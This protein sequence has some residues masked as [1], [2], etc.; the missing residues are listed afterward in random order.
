[1]KRV[2][3]KKTESDE[4]IL[5]ELT[6]EECALVGALLSQ[7]KIADLG[8]SSGKVVR[9]LEKMNESME[10]LPEAKDDDET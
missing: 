8:P 9:I 3:V 1:M 2:P 7:F 5:L 6:K 10:A 4:L